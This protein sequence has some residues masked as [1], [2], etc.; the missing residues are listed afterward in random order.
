MSRV[1]HS[2][3]LI[4]SPEVVIDSNGHI[5]VFAILEVDVDKQR[6]EVKSDGYF[7]VKAAVAEL[8]RLAEALLMSDPKYNRLSRDV[9]RPIWPHHHHGDDYHDS[10]GDDYHGNSD[11]D[12]YHDTDNNQHDYDG[13]TYAKIND[14]SQY[15]VDRIEQKIV[16]ANAQLKAYTKTQIHALNAPSHDALRRHFGID[17]ILPH[18]LIVVAAPKFSRTVYAV[19]RLAVQ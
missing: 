17:V 13:R 3:N 16:E 9:E 12:D 7:T 4:D 1:Y 18:T 8:Y 11:D 2:N 14:Y 19:Y 15:D 10:S 5:N 6:V